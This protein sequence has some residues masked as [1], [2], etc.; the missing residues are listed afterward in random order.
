MHAERRLAEGAGEI[1]AGKEHDRPAAPTPGMS[2]N[3]D[4]VHDR[5][6]A[7]ACRGANLSDTSHVALPNSSSVTPSRFRHL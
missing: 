1:A 2:V 5:A 6:V 7:D 4:M 3:V